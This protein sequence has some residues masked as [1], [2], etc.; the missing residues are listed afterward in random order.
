MLMAILAMSND[1]RAQAVPAPAVEAP[2]ERARRD[3][4]RVY[5]LIL[6]HADKPRKV[7]EER[8]IATP[9]APRVAPGTASGA[10]LSGISTPKAGSLAT[11]SV[12]VAAPPEQAVP[13]AKV[14]ERAAAEGTNPHTFAAKLPA[15]V[16][17]S[18]PG[19]MPVPSAPPAMAL[20]PASVPLPLPAAPAPAAP[21]AVAAKVLELVSSV[22]PD[23][24]SHLL[25]RL[26]QGSVTIN[27]DVLPDGTVGRTAI[28]KSSHQGLNAA[29]QAAV[30]AW[31]FKP[32]SATTAG[33]T[34]LRFE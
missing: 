1:V 25:R 19:E 2:I 32:V 18:L 21:P 30:A 4:E 29:A 9:A 22:E 34:E 17:G 28:V 3:A 5:Q 13:A 33:V 11:V 31:R 14:T 16:E 15:V 20:A 12:P 23:F 7:R 24:P 26:G 8:V 6:L 27:F 10:A